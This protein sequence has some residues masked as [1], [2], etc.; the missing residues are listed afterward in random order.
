MQI[1]EYH[2]PA[3]ALTRPGR[4]GRFLA[5]LKR[6]PVLCLLILSPGIP[7]YLSSSSNVGLLILSPAVFLLL[8]GANIGMYGPGVL[9]IREAM[10]RWQKG[11]AS[12]LLLGAA[13][14]IVEEGIALA[15][16]FN[17]LA[18]PV[19]SLGFFG[20]FAGVNWVWATGLLM[21]HAVF[22]ISLPIL[23]L[24]LALPET[25]G[26]TLLS[27]RQ[28]PLVLGIWVL[29]I[30]F[31]MAF[32]VFGMHFWLG[33]T[34]LGGS[35]AVVL[36]LVLLAYWM[37]PDALRARPMALPLAPWGMF[38][39]GASLFPGVLLLESFLPALGGPAPAVIVALLVW[40]TLLGWL[41]LR[42]FRTTGHESQLVGLVAG[43]LASVA[44]F[45][46]LAAWAFP[47]VL[48]LD[49]VLVV[50]LAR[51]W[52]AHRAQTLIPVI[53]PPPGALG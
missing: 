28:I 48:A 39:L 46:L 27:R 17:P 23:L 1:P 37:P 26:K 45:G 19:G 13:Y 21:F 31:L 7:E 3:I 33:P 10:V 40:Y 22:S 24:G 4:L 42:G 16:L 12:V 43:L 11:W 44:T 15:T 32:I 52:V 34:L 36:G 25:R 51:L 8:L 14:A 35:V 38:V 6:H 50:F 29:D 49:V 5:F 20:H 9:L 41:V 18:S 2:S 47:V 53:A 30:L